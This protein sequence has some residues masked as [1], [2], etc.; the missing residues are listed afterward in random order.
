M[1][2]W[3]IKPVSVVCWSDALPTELHPHPLSK[4]KKGAA[5]ILAS[6]VTYGDSLGDK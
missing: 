5:L 6:A 3:G 4:K 2:H 1:L